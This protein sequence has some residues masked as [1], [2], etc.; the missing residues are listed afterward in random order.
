MS[1]DEWLIDRNVPAAFLVAGTVVLGGRCQ[2]RC[3]PLEPAPGA[4]GRAQFLP[5][6]FHRCR[7][8]PRALRLPDTEPHTH[9]L[10][11]AKTCR[12]VGLPVLNLGI[13]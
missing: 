5:A 12:H 9:G 1:S 8:R 2:C 6:Y 3:P 7:L 4:K 11:T 13:R 10:L